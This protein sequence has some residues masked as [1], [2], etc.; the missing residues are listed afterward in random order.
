MQKLWPN[1]SPAASSTAS[2]ICSNAN[3]ARS[4]YPTRLAG[5]QAVAQWVSD[6]AFTYSLAATLRANRGKKVDLSFVQLM[7]GVKERLKKLKYP[8]VPNLVGPREV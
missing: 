7:D 8:Q 3:A 6:G 4:M 5:R 1:Y 2:A